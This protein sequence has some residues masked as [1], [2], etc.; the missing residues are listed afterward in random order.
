MEMTV[1]A[2]AE[3]MDVLAH[4]ADAL[5]ELAHDEDMTEFDRALRDLARCVRTEAAA[6]SR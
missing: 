3:A 5:R 1:A 4:E 6:K 2:M